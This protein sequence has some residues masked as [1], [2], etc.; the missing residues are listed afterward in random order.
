M[1]DC[2]LKGLERKTTYIY[3]F[4]PCTPMAPGI[5]SNGQNCFFL[6]MVMLHI[7]LTALMSLTI[8]KQNIFTY[9]LHTSDPWD[10]GLFY[11]EYGH[12]IYQIK[13]NETYDK[14]EGKYF[15]LTHTFDH[16]SEA[17]R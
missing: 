17:K 6:K 5:R 15:V 1:F 4:D 3:I 2:K 10:G 13:G 7:K 9:A 14:N 8:C 11:S 12:V 16:W